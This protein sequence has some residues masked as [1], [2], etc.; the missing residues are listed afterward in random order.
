[1][2]QPLRALALDPWR[3]FVHAGMA[4]GAVD[5]HID[6]N[7][8]ALMLNAVFNDV[9][10]Y[11]MQRLGIQGGTLH[12]LDVTNCQTPDVERVFDDTTRLLERAIVLH[13]SAN[14]NKRVSG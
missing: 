9:G 8:A 6:P 4:Q 10:S 7:L 12:E 1:M 3:T 14:L 2:L 5:P 13:H 11:V